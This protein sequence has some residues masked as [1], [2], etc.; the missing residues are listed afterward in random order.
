M[1]GDAGGRDDGGE[2]G[3]GPQRKAAPEPPAPPPP[4]PIITRTL[5]ERG[6]WSCETIKEKHAS[7]AL[8]LID[9][10]PL[11]L[12]DEDAPKRVQGA[13][14]RLRVGTEIYVSA[15]VQ[16]GK[17]QAKQTFKPG[18]SIPIPSGQFAFLITL[19]TVHIPNDAI[20][21]ITLRSKNAKFRGLV[22]VSG[23]HVDPGYEGK[24]VF[25]V[26]NAGPAIVHV[27]Q[28]DEWFEIFFADLDRKTDYQP[29]KGYREIPTELISPISGAFYS[30]EGLN[31]K[32]E[33]VR[34][35]LDDRVQRLERE[36]GIM[37]WAVTL[38]LGGLIAFG[39]R[40]CSESDS[41][42]PQPESVE[43]ANRTS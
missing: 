24:L 40:T 27:S 38:V 10:K 39:V 1:Q 41:R 34:D 31:A 33:E 32:M 25:A 37:R 18:E 15:T 7:K 11:E 36:S 26:Y 5:Q 9:G 8:F 23:F 17:H 21:W 20:A 2:V 43:S 16:E 3:K 12:E 42:R 22:N 29:D 4:S 30:F 13:S 14:C 35:D 6:F 19:E 28:G